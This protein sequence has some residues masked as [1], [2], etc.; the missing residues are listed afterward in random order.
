LKSAE[1]KSFSSGLKPTVAI[2]VTYP[3]VRSANLIPR[4]SEKQQQ[5]PFTVFSHAKL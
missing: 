3:N 5:C 4:S 2:S 1:P